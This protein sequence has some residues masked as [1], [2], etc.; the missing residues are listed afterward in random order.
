MTHLHYL[1][2]VY[3]KRHTTLATNEGQELNKTRTNN[4]SRY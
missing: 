3:I 4:L 1:L 2:G